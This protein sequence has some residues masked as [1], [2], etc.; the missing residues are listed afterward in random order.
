MY[1]IG[2]TVIEPTYFNFTHQNTTA[3]ITFFGKH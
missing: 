3:D 1:L 2:Y